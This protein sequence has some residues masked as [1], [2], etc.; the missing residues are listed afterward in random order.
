MIDRD[1][2][3]GVGP[4]GPWDGDA[5]LSLAKHTVGA[6]SWASSITDD[7]ARTIA[8]KEV[9]CCYICDVPVIAVI[10]PV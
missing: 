5:V 1:L 6:P 8:R 2:R 9:V 10:V 4:C 3:A 7:G